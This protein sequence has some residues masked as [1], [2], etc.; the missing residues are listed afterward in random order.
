M[1][2]RTFRYNFFHIHACICT[3]VRTRRHTHTHTHAPA[4][5]YARARTH[6]KGK[7]NLNL[8]KN[9]CIFAPASHTDTYAHVKNS[10]IHTCVRIWTHA[11]TCVRA[12]RH[13]QTHKAKET[14]IYSRIS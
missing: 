1:K 4:C 3:Y 8:F 12:Q 14:W 2:K 9:S 13:T 11:R 10:C 5:A 6:T 7:G